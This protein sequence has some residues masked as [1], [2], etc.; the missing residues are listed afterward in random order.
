MILPPKKASALTV[1]YNGITNSIV[2]EIQVC[3][4]FEPAGPGIHP[5][6][7]KFK[8]IWDTG[9]TN[10]VIN[11]KVVK[12]VGLIPT[13]Q[14]YTYTAGGK[15]LCNT[16][17]VNIRLP[18]GVGFSGVRVTEGQLLGNEDVLIGMDIISAGDFAVSNTNGHTKMSF[19]IPSIGEI[20]FIPDV[21]RYNRAHTTEEERRKARNRAKAAR[22]KRGH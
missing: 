16:Y 14:T 9:A 15:M 19:R 17:L 2:S 1:T 11:S 8:C 7:S 6:W 4:A 20:D 10:S 3:E 21:D 12:S 13:G 22:K 5:P 18:G